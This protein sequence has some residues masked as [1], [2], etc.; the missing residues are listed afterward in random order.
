[1]KGATITRIDRKYFI[2]HTQHTVS[3]WV[4][5]KKNQCSGWFSEETGTF[6]CI[7]CEAAP[8]FFFYYYFLSKKYSCFGVLT[9]ALFKLPSC[10]QISP[11]L[12]RH[13]S[14]WSETRP[15][16]R[17]IFFLANTRKNDELFLPSPNTGEI[18]V[19]WYEENHNMLWRQ[20]KK[21]I[22]HL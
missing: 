15:P 7:S 18:A 22:V 21:H 16:A 6:V 8:C 14:Y 2:T 11:Q 17:N 10:K 4:N 20:E 1:M 9:D 19:A 13:G 5:L 12:V 3:L